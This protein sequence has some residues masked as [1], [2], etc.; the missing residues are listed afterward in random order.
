MSSWQQ[1]GQQEHAT[2]EAEYNA[3]QAKGYAEGTLDRLS[4]KKD[5]VIGAVVGDRKQEVEGKSN[6]VHDHHHLTNPSIGNARQDKGQAK[7]SLNQPTS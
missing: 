3:A 2:G 1:S 7:Q 6:L 4:G 5:A